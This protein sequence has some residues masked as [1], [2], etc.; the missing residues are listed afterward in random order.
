MPC[1]MNIDKYSIF[2]LHNVDIMLLVFLEMFL[3]NAGVD[4][5]SNFM[6]FLHSSHA[7]HLYYFQRQWHPSLIIF[8]WSLITL[9]LEIIPSYLACTSSRWSSTSS[10]IF[11]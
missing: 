11:C 3:G 7:F 5:V 8:A 6:V 9:A 2:F 4:T 10:S 1:S